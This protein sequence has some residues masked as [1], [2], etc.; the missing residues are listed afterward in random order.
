M[1]HR[2]NSSV[3]QHEL[4][5]GENLLW[6]GKPDRLK[7]F[8]LADIFIIP[9]SILFMNIALHVE[10]ALFSD[11]PENIY[12]LIYS[13]TINTLFVLL[14]FYYTLGRYIYKFLLRK[15]TFYAVTNKRILIKSTF[16]PKKLQTKF[17]KDT[18]GANIVMRNNNTGDI[19]F[20]KNDFGTTM[21]NNTGLDLFFMLSKEPSTPAFYNIE[22]VKAIHS[23]ITDIRQGKYLKSN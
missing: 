15:N 1:N 11:L 4:M 17:I 2:E 10:Y 9:F 3:F 14:G 12:T 7:L 5:H 20:G 16:F 8:T 22:N 6:T 19:I 13:V 18:A 23:L 21:Y